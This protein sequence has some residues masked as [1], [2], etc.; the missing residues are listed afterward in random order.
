MKWSFSRLSSYEH[1][2][3]CFYLQYILK[4]PNNYLPESNYW[5]ENG[6]VVHETLQKIFKGELKTEDANQYYIDHYDSDVCY[7]AKPATM[8][9]TFEACSTYFAKV[10]FNWLK[11]YEILGVEL[12]VNL[13]VS[14]YKF[15]GFID[16]L[17][18]RKDNNKIILM[19]HKSGQ[20]FFKKDGTLKKSKE[21]SFYSYRKQMYM[22]CNAVK[23]MYGQ[24]P[25]MIVWNHF[26]DGGKFSTIPFN[27]SDYDIA[28][29][30]FFDTI[31]QIEQEQDFPPRL[32]FFYCVN[33][34]SFRHSCEYRK[35]E[36][37]IPSKY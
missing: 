5:A 30:W 3:Y 8:K 6:S 18:R 7:K 19:D 17:L 35:K 12:E 2:K 31:H 26:K 37:K 4:D 10:D 32:D 28:M 20:Y 1:C 22:Y 25:D 29:E 34:C 15:I 14:G 9:K 27:Q 21:E 11:Y 24:F 13:E 23:Q 33:L 16:L 36:F